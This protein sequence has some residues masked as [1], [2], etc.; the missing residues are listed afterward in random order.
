MGYVSRKGPDGGGR[1]GAGS[2]SQD[3]TS[4]QPSLGQ[5][6]TGHGVTV[7]KLLH[8]RGRQGRGY[9]GRGG[10]AQK[11]KPWKSRNSSF[12]FFATLIV[13]LA[14]LRLC[15]LSA[16]LS[17]DSTPAALRLQLLPQQSQSLPRSACVFSTA[18]VTVTVTASEARGRACL[19]WC[20]SWR[21]VSLAYAL[22]SECNPPIGRSRLEV[23]ASSAELHRRSRP[24][25]P[26][27]ERQALA[28]AWKEGL[29]QL[30]L[31]GKR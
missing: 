5:W 11:W 29:L 31:G 1:G 8:I 7:P 26:R 17:H 22:C 3:S 23:R 15:P 14:L 16:A 9:R 12:C 19:C 20:F 2:V 18:A 4:T 24:P 21:P 30:W 28:T 6:S 13:R 10:Q 25:R 27:Q